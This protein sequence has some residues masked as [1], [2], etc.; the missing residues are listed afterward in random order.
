MLGNS[1]PRLPGRKARLLLAFGCLG[2]LDCLGGFLVLAL[3]ALHPPRGVDELLFASEKGMAA[4]ADL[5]SHEIRFISRTRL[6]RTAA[7]TM[8]CNFVIIRVDT[9][10]HAR[11]LP[12]AVLHG[13]PE[14]EYSRVAKLADNP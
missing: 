12:Q 8:N 13:S 6:E 2:C 3:E 11:S 9:G 4:R 1:T 7:G 5:H 14:R 10:F